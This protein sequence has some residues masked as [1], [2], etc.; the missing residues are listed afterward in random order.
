[1]SPAET[2]A[3]P[4]PASAPAEPVP[5]TRRVGGRSLIYTATNALQKGAMFLLLPVYTRYLTPAE[6]GIVA[7]VMAVNSL[8]AVLFAFS[9]HSAMTR[10]YFEYREDPEK[11]KD[12]WGT[13]LTAV[14]L[15]SVFGS[16]VLLLV[17]EPLARTLLGDI[18]F[19][20]FLG[21]GL[22]TAMFQP[23]FTIFLALLQTKEEAGRY[24]L[25]SLA[26]FA[27]T[28]LLTLSFVVALRWGAAG[29]LAG[30]MIASA[31]FFVVSITALRKDVRFGLR[32]EHLRTG[33]GYSFPLV[34]HSLA[35]QVS[36]ITDRMLLNALLNTAAAGVYNVGYLVGSALNLMADGVNRA[37]VPASM[38]VLKRQEPGQ[39]AQLRSLGLLIITG[40]VALASFVA[41]FGVDIIRLLTT[42]DF[43]G[44]FVVVPY[45]AFAFVLTGM[46]FVFVNILFFVRRATKFIAICTVLAAIANVGLNFALIPSYGMRGAAAAA[47]LSHLLATT[48]V[49]AVG[50]RYEAVDWP[51][52]RFALLYAVGFAASVLV[53]ESELHRQI[54]LRSGLYL[55]LLAL[56]STIA[57][58]DPL[59]LVHRG[60]SLAKT[61][62][63]GRAG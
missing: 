53:V 20:P 32:R 8:L 27:A 35:S 34:P 3:V 59:Y 22:L 19:W 23:M 6:Y 56:L 47:V 37:Y 13:Q 4:L 44:S 45:I 46:Y 9:L 57:W 11:L 54:L 40:Y 25:F 52:L 7:V 24:S 58:G 36:A 5:L 49:A 1:M 29:A 28:L 39:L 17:G 2:Q 50:R 33:F 41:F 55:G 21:I 18:P 38:D 63:L 48:A 61:W 31:V 43:I 15:I 60:R 26:Q 62:N 51:Y 14:L 30:T 42:R 10:F 16:G 12:F